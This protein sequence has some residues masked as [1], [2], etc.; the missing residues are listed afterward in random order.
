M[1]KTFIDELVLVLDAIENP[2]FS[3]AMFETKR[4]LKS[5]PGVILVEDEIL[6]IGIAIKGVAVLCSLEE[7]SKLSST[8][9]EKKKIQFQ[10]TVNMDNSPNN[11][12]A[13]QYEKFNCSGSWKKIVETIVDHL[14][15]GDRLMS[16]G[17]RKINFFSQN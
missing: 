3:D 10:F 5:L 9:K 7:F 4:F 2:G 1:K 16:L 17:F 6:P 12:W 11:A 8:D 14:S 13:F 15:P